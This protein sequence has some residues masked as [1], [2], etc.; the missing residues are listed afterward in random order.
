MLAGVP[1]VKEGMLL[2]PADSLQPL[3]YG[4]DIGS[5]AVLRL[6]G[7]TGAEPEMQMHWLRLRKDSTYGAA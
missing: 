7:R 4:D 5:G 1:T 6:A 3:M 2:P